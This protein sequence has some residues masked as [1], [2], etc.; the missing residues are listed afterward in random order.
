METGCFQGSHRL[1]AE[2]WI[3]QR[4]VIYGKRVILTHGFFK[5]GAKTP[6]G[7]IERAHMIK[8]DFERRIKVWKEN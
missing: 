6:K 1:H 4:D 5:K 7:E 2:M 8:E 3:L